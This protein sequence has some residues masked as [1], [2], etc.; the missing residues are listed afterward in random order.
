M[1]DHRPATLQAAKAIN[2]EASWEDRRKAEEVLTEAVR[3]P[4]KVVVMEKTDGEKTFYY[5]NLYPANGQKPTALFSETSYTGKHN[6][7]FEIKEDNALWS[8]TSESS[9]RTGR[10]WEMM[11]VSLTDDDH[12]VIVDSYGYANI[13]HSDENLT[14]IGSEIRQMAE[15]ELA[16]DFEP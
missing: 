14:V 2:P 6:A 9:S 1:F 4:A 7:G 5:V 8:W 16:V 13:G 15:E 11:L 3:Q 12:K 10:H